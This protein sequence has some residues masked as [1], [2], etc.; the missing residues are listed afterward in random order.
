MTGDYHH[1]PGSVMQSNV[2]LM[3][4]QTGEKA[5]APEGSLS[6][7]NKMYLFFES[8][9]LSVEELEQKEGQKPS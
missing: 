1:K 2:M 3:F 8:V 5:M 9:N 4:W 6:C 7:G